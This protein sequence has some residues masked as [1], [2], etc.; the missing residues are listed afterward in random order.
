VLAEREAAI[1]SGILGPHFEHLA[2]EWARKF[3]TDDELGGVA[4]RVA[5]AVLSD[6]KAKTS[7]EVDVVALA[8][9][10]GERPKV[11]A[12]G[13]AKY[14]EAKR[15]TTDIDRLDH[16]RDLIVATRSAQFDTTS[17]K[18]M[19]FSAFGFDD[20]VEAMARSRSDITLIDLQALYGAES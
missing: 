17:I 7:R 4:S 2:R 11:L 12:I 8:S 20:S 14:T 5:P 15:T 1:R 18:L 16:L 6:P 13:E 19:L 10:Y 9:G 3:A